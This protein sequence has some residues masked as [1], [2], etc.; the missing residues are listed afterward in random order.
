MN[1]RNASPN[2]KARISTVQSLVRHY[3]GKGTFKVLK[4]AIDAL[5]CNSQEL[6]G[7]Q[8]AFRWITSSVSHSCEVIRRKGIPTKSIKTLPI[9]I[10]LFGTNIL[11]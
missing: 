9:I 7:L 3:S 4:E 2:S 8:D 11:F 5:V 10:T 6:I 1:I